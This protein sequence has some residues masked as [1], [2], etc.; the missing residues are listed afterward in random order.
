MTK[1]HNTLFRNN[2]AAYA[3][4][5]LDPDDAHLLEGHL[6]TCAECQAELADYMAVSEG[7]LSALP[8]Q[9]PPSVLKEQLAAHLPRRE[10]AIQKRLSRPFAG[11]SFGQI[12]TAAV[13]LLLLASNLFSAIQVRSLQ[14]Q[15]AELA[16]RLE[17]GQSAIAMLA[18]PGTEKLSI[19]QGVAGSL[20][21]NKDTN[22]A[23]LFTWNLGE[24]PE[25]ET[26]Q[27][28]LIDE[29][30][31]RASGGLFVAQP[32]Q[33]YTSTSVSLPAPITDFVGLGVTV[34]PRGGSPGPTG[35]NVLKV[36]F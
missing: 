29:Q 17:A 7:L 22:T 27:I 23:V 20:L 33:A 5:T 31:N 15:Q 3:L 14:R 25:N 35:K 24:L 12:A 21:V 13:V 6:E 32:G 18:Y 26:Y 28:W 8:P 10:Q 30:G 1:E 16:Q 11:I 19:S 2:L 36:S 4:G 34:E 9:A